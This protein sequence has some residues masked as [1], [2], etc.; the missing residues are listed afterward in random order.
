MIRKI[1]NRLSEKIMLPPKIWSATTIQPEA[2][3]L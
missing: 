2:V 1:G 3:A